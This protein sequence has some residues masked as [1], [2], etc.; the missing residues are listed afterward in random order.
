MTLPIYVYNQNLPNPP[1]DPGDDVGGM[2]VNSQSIYAYTAVDHVPFQSTN[3]GCHNQVT[4]AQNQSAPALLTGQVGD[5]FANNPSGQS[6]PFWQ[7]ALGA[8]QM[9]GASSAGTNGYTT[10]PGGIIVQWGIVN[11]PHSGNVFDSGDQGIVTFA[12][13]NIAFPTACFG[14]LTNGLYNSNAEDEPSSAATISY[15]QYTLSKLQ[16]NWT[17]ASNSAKYTRFFWVAIGN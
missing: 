9:L 15:D 13:A 7:N 5:I 8:F 6:W 16:F 10:L 4:F 1:D 2:Q 17:F 14:V 12:M 3:N 11:G